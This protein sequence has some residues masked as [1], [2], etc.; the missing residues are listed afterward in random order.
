MIA[1][2]TW[3]APRR[4]PFCTLVSATDPLLGQ[5]KTITIAFITAFTITINSYPSQ[6][7]QSDTIH[8]ST[9]PC[10]NLSPIIYPQTISHQSHL[11]LEYHP[12]VKMTPPP[13]PPHLSVEDIRQEASSLDKAVKEDQ[14]SKNVIAILERLEAGVQATAD[15]LRVSS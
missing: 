13:S 10:S 11:Q 8:R 3:E 5:Y 2:G 12:S 9:P 15:L 4:R 6:P 1:T 14:P 7:S